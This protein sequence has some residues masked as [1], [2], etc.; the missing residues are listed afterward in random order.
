MAPA[1]SSRA[2]RSVPA[3]PAVSLALP[4]GVMACEHHKPAS[5]SA[6]RVVRAS[7][8]EGRLPL[9]ASSPPQPVAA[10]LQQGGGGKQ[11]QPRA[12]LQPKSS[13]PCKA[14][15]QVR[16]TRRAGASGALHCNL[17]ALHQLLLPPAAAHAGMPGS[18]WKA[19]VRWQQPSQRRR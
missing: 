18:P 16:H 9:V 7:C 10:A 17:G 3:E 4:P 19:A 6:F 2:G 1:T 12:L 15:P 13:Q 8:G 14:Q 5:A 11:R